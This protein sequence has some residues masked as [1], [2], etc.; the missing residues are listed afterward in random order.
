MRVRVVAATTIA[1][2]VG[3]ACSS[4]GDTTAVDS[5]APAAATAEPS[6][7]TA[8]TAEPTPTPQPERA[9]IDELFA[10]TDTL[11]VA[12]AGGDQDGPHSTFFAFDQAVAA[13]ADVLE[14]DVQ[15]SGDGVLVVQ[16][17]STVDRTTNGTGNVADFT[18]AELQALD[19]GYWWSPQCWPCRDLAEDAYVH[20]GVRTG[21][22]EP[23]VGASADD[24]R[25]VT[26]A[27]LVERYPTHPID[28]EIKGSAPDALPVVDAL[29]ADINAAGIEDSVVVVSFDDVLVAAFKEQL[30]GADTSPGVGEMSAWLLSGQPLGEHR[31]V[32]VPPDF[33]GLDVITPDFWTAVADARVDVWVWPSDAEA[34]ENA[35]FYQAMIDQGAAGI[36]AGRPAQVPD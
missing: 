17:D 13:G 33:D 22:V 7:T 20:R 23:P 9:T 24:F 29:V 6:P 31:I 3:V 4:S 26:F 8:P 36:I 2:V 14:V 18:L 10:R 1:L 15:L 21:A 12:H 30:P 25:I 5:P 35:A 19:A 16:H 11:N 28:I 32:Q 34:Q 27:E